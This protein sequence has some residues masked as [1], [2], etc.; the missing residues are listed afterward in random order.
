M[1]HSSRI[2]ML[3]PRFTFLPYIWH[4]YTTSLSSPIHS[5]SFMPLPYRRHTRVPCRSS[6]RLKCCCRLGIM[7]PMLSE[8]VPKRWPCTGSSWCW[9][10]RTGSN[11][12]TPRWPSIKLLSRWAEQGHICAIA[13]CHSLGFSSQ[14]IA[15]RS[16][17]STRSVEQSLHSST[18]PTI[19]SVNTTKDR[20]LYF[21]LFLE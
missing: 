1:F 21:S 3:T 20:C 19:C 11:L 12:S 2:S 14:G 18:V 8:S 10:W 4:I 13:E 6:R 15:R 16:C 17:V 5:P 9:R 7:M